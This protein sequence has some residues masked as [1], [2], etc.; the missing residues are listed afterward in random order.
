[1]IEFIHRFVGDVVLVHSYHEQS[2]KRHRN[3]WTCSVCGKLCMET[4]HGHGH[5]TLAPGAPG[6]KHLGQTAAAGDG[7]DGRWAKTEKLSTRKPLKKT[8]LVGGLEHFFLHIYIYIGNNHPNWFSYFSEGWLNHHPRIFEDLGVEIV[9]VFGADTEEVST[10]DPG[11]AFRVFQWELSTN[12]ANR[13]CGPDV[14]DT[15]TI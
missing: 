15:P 12:I 1:M 11:I 4:C 9:W 3:W 14:L 5:H 13:Y 7:G 6:S 2:W 8:Y 10:A